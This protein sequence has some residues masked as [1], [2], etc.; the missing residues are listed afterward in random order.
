VTEEQQNF[1]SWDIYVPYSLP[2]TT[3]A[4]SWRFSR[5]IW[6]HFNTKL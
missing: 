4:H 3:D 6:R 2:G 5:Y 1:N